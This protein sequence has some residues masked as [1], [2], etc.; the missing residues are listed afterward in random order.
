MEPLTGAALRPEALALGASERWYAVQTLS[1][2]EERAKFHLRQQ[3]FRVFLPAISTAVRHARK[4]RVG[5]SALFPGYLFVALDLQRDRWRSINGTIG[6]SRVVM[7][8]TSPSPVPQGVVESLINFVDEEGICRFDQGFELGQTVRVAAGP[9]ADMVG[10]IIRLDA[11]GRVRVLLS[12]LG[13]DVPTTLD[14]KDVQA[15]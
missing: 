10:T 11:R 3:S 12:L 14:H 4:T 13:G 7:G 8:R 9:F 6:V 2:R 1:K 15:A 5:K